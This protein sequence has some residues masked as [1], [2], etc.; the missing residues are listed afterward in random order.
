MYACVCAL[1][2]TRPTE[3][4]QQQR[5]QQHDSDISEILQKKMR[6]LRKHLNL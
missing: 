2:L 4:T 3:A 5:Q 1:Y 6:S